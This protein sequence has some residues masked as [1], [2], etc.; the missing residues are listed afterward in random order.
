MAS[1]AQSEGLSQAW[2]ETWLE[3]IGA[4]SITLLA[5]GVAI[6]HLL[7]LIA[8]GLCGLDRPGWTLMR[9]LPPP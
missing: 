4:P 2:M 8:Q 7:R 3:L 9:L 5:S 1:A 6:A